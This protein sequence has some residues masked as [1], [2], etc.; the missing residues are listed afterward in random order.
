MPVAIHIPRLG[1]NMEEGIFLGWLRRD[2]EAVRAGEPLFSLEGE[3][4]AQEIEAVED[5]IVWIDPNGPA[6]GAVVP[7]GA[8]I[9]A[10]LR[11][12]EGPPSS[13]PVPSAIRVV[14][15][16]VA[17]AAPVPRAVVRDRPRSSPLARRIARELNIDW[18]T[19]RGGGRSGR[20]RK[21]DV[22]AAAQDGATAGSI[23]IRSTRRTIAARMVA[24]H[25]ETAPV[26]LTTTVDATNLVNLRGQFRATNAGQVPSYTDFVVKL[27]ALALRDHP[28]LN[29]RWENDRI[30]LAAEVSIGIAVD[31]EGGLL[32][33]VIRGADGLGLRQIAERSCDLIP[34]ARDGR[35]AAAEM[36]GG[37]F[38]ITN[39]GAFGV[40]AFTPIINLPECAILGLGRI[41]RAPVM[42]GER[43]EGRDRL[44]LSLTFDHRIVDGAPASRFLQDV[45][46][47]IENPGPWLLT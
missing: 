34:R 47:R 15:A 6:P 9:G 29:A 25:T 12:G 5:G 41:A 18:T 7:V 4:A 17:A 28:S 43:V 36:Q 20:I 26:T 46:R 11:A 35:L 32:V 45:G 40:E 1:W 39:L 3:K 42:V 37:T 27:T 2:G 23:P 21:A 30:E 22:L 14:P 16:V 8:A 10:L 33:P 38:T 24:S 19:L 31:T 44:T 13:A